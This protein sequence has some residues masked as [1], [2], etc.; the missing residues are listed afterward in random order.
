MFGVAV[1]APLLAPHDPYDQELSSR[2]HKFRERYPGIEL[3]LLLIDNEELD[4][5]RNAGRP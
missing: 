2:L 1:F 3:S 5:A 4:H